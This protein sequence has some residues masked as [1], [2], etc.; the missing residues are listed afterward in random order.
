MDKKINLLIVDDHILF[1]KGL[2]QLIAG[3]DQFYVSGEASNGEEALEMVSAQPVDVI[4]LD[5]SMPIMDGIT[6]LRTLRDQGNSTPVLILSISDDPKDVI[7]GINSGANGYILKSE[8]F[9]VLCSSIQQVFEG[10]YALSK[11]LMGGLFRAVRHKSSFPIDALLSQRETEVLEYLQK[12]IKVEEIAKLLFV[13]ENTIKTHL[14]HIYEKMN[15]NSR[16]EAVE[17][18]LAWGIL[19]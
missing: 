2:V 5:L 1:R 4:L 16:N 8:E 6:V 3:S 19:K 11:D 18:G 12:E 15:V 10:G 14:K 17:K 9:D 13:S 7:A